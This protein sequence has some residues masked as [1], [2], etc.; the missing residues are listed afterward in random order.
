MPNEEERS[1]CLLEV[2]EDLFVRLSQFAES[3]GRTLQQVA[4]EAL[5]EFIKTKKA[6]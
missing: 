1:Y 4:D 6:K 3:S 5:E 2:P